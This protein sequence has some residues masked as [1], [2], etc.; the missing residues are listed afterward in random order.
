MY[1]S[2]WGNYP[3]AKAKSTKLE[4]PEQAQ[5][6]LLNTPAPLIARGNGRCYGDSALQTEMLSTLSYRQL[7]DFDLE[8]GIVQVQAGMLLDDLLQTIVPKGWFLG[9]IP[10]TKMITVGGAMASNVHGKNHHLA[11]AFGD[12]VLS[13]DL[14]N[15][16][17]QIQT[18]SRESNSDQFNATIGGLGTSGIILRARIQ[19]VPIETSYYHQHSL[20]ANS[21]SEILNLFEQ[22]QA[23][24]YLVAW[25]D[26]LV[27]KERL[28]AG[29]LLVGDSC[30][31]RDLPINFQDDALQVHNPPRV[32]IPRIPINWLMNPLSLWLNNALYKWKNRSGRRIV[33]Y[34]QF[35]FP[36]DSLANWNNLYGPSGFLQYQFVVGFAEAEQ[37]LHGVLKTIRE[38]GQLPYLMVLKR[39]GP[40]SK[41]GAATDFPM[42]GYSLAID[43]KN[44]ERTRTLLHTL[45]GIVI[46]H[47][48]RIYL[49]KDARLPAKAFALM[50]P[51]A[52]K[53]P[54][55]F[56]SL[57][58]ERIYNL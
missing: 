32:R 33:H 30:S 25:L 19:L 36:L 9:V 17:G 38:S 20:K 8:Q 3:K 23:S 37:C 22:N 4:S 18:C 41:H 29:M 2:N 53:K 21:L 57:Q 7:E 44:N 50:Y 28:G 42:P 51:E 14:L 55:K 16:A 24:P 1:L 45:D 31:V 35:F 5:T 11:G 34:S 26:G 58:S 49:T 56:R 54:G 12:Y 13:F 40:S 52:T 47:Q 6:M 15:E 46:K 43:F 48:G 39:M 10:G 27:S